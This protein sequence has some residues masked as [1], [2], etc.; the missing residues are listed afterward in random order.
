VSLVVEVAVPIW[1]SIKVSRGLNPVLETNKEAKAPAGCLQ[2]E[3]SPGLHD[4]QID[5]IEQSPSF[6]HGGHDGVELM[7]LAGL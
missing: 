1:Y 7:A 2:G 5:Q 4:A 6:G 3:I